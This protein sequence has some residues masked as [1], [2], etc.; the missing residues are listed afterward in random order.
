MGQS[1]V[2]A[3]HANGVWATG[4]ADPLLAAVRLSGKQAPRRGRGRP[5]GT[6]ADSAREPHRALRQA[7]GAA[8]L[9]GRPL[10]AVRFSVLLAAPP[11][12][13]AQSSGVLLPLCAAQLLNAIFDLA[14]RRPAW[15]R[16]ST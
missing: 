14:Q 5:G 13:R 8:P 12:I 4:A 11:T 3:A 16:L 10:P 9:Q 2:K 1:V 7:S 15:Q 6:G